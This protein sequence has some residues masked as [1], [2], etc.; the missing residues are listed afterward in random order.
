MLFWQQPNHQLTYSDQVHN[1][2]EKIMAQENTDK[3]LSLRTVDGRIAYAMKFFIDRGFS[4]QSSAGIVGN[5]VAESSIDPTRNQMGGGPGRGVAQWTVDQR[6]QTF[7][8]FADNRKLDPN[9]LDAQLRFIVHEMPSAMGSDAQKI[10]SMTDADAAAELFMRK[11]ERPG[12]E[13][14]EER[15]DFAS[16]AIRVYTGAK[17]IGPTIRADD[18]NADIKLGK[19]KPQDTVEINQV[20]LAK[21]F[22]SKLTP[23][24]FTSV[25]DVTEDALTSARNYFLNRRQV[26]APKQTGVLSQE[27]NLI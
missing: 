10:K 23:Q 7:L 16:R 15:K 26:T 3:K 20:G 14:L 18:R 4:V 8:K 21:D 27:S 5:L 6:W 2:I 24:A 9:T 25:A 12:I 17:S 11:Y 19:V 22:F 13:R 1:I